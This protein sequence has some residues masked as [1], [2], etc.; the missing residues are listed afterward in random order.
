MLNQCATDIWDGKLRS[1][2]DGMGMGTKV[3]PM[4]LSTADMRRSLTE[5]I[6]SPPWR[7]AYRCYSL[8]VILHTAEVNEI[9]QS[10]AL[11]SKTSRTVN[12]AKSHSDHVYRVFASRWANDN[13]YVVM[14]V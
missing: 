2:C 10:I 14:E 4:Q 1:I 5:L 12:P 8:S 3:F 13:E 7:T 11:S 9:S 6:S